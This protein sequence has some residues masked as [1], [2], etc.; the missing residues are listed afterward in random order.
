M[1]NEKTIRIGGAS[2]Y[3]GD[4]QEAPR[5]LV[6]KGDIDYLV[7][8]Y[9]AEVTMSILVRAKQK[10]PE[11]GYARDFIDLAMKPLLHEIK[12]RGIKVV[13]NAGGVNVEACAAALAKVAE[14]AGVDLKIGTV[15]GDNL[16]D[17]IATLRSEGTSEMFSGVAMPDGMISAN[18]YL[19][20]FPIA[21]ALDNGADVVITG[22]CVDSAVTLG[23]LIHEFGWTVDDYDRLAAGSLAGHI[24]ECGAQAT[25]GNFTDWR[26]TVDGWDDMGYPIAVCRADGTFAITKPDGT[27]GIVSRLSVG[28]QILYEI[29]DPSAYIMPDV[30]CDFSGVT[31]TETK[32]DWLEIA[33]VKGRAPTSTY[34][35]SGTYKD[36][37][38]ATASTVITGF[39]VIEKGQAYAEALLKRTR[40]LFMERNLGDY[41]E[42]A[43]HLIGAETLW[44]GN[45]REAALQSREII[46][47]IDV[48]H[49]EKAAL[50][51]FSKETTGVGLSMTTGRCSGGATG[52]PKV[53]PVVAQFAFQ[54]DKSRIE[55]NVY[56][57]NKPVN[58]NLPKPASYSPYPAWKHAAVEKPAA[59]TP[60]AMV[61]VPL[62]KLAA[63]R[64]GDKGNNANIGVIARK[65]EYLPWIKQGATEKA[66][67]KYFGH[68]LKGEVYRFDLPGMEAVNFLLTDTL[69]G[70]G[71][72]T[73]HLDNLAKTYAQQL[74]ALPIRVPAEVADSL[75]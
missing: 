70:G 36:G 40:R 48:R 6:M 46:T 2:G 17:D 29:G 71:T 30:I 45:A 15:D 47:R 73:L 10:S 19:G 69:G 53:T 26:D 68:V 21:A 12:A 55:P 39:D 18:A 75:G 59:A 44:G 28:E 27:G 38:R 16:S 65:A 51:L 50:E 4:S 32:K 13:A 9:L 8:D 31:L 35:V 5:Q 20:A 14:E 58:A 24:L 57:N 49:D 34:K 62:I 23:P 64:S 33:N 67:A 56:I 54:I 72:S 52:R 41:R 74:L 42:T 61:E 63:A 3:W 22:R 37:F 25:G 43:I 60:E 7:F 11:L 1:S 66:V